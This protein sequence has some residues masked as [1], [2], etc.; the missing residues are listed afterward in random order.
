MKTHYL[1]TWVEYFQAVRRGD[2]DFELRKDDR[3]FQV[4]DVLILEEWD[5]INDE[6]TG[7]SIDKVVK[8]KLTGGQFGL[9]EGYCIMSF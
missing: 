3:D 9:E 6:H 8:Y 7:D 5:H 4:G 2:K 1:K